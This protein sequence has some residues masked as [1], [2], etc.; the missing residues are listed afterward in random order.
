MKSLLNFDDCASL[1]NETRAVP[2]AEEPARCG[3][4]GCSSLLADVG[5]TGSEFNE[6][7][8]DVS[9]QIAFGCPFVVFVGDREE[10]E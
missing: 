7:L 2:F 1:T 4:R 6:E 9:N 3:Q 8:G 5:E 10:V